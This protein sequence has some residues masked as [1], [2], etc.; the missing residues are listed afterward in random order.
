MGKV[1]AEMSM[2]LDGI[3]ADAADGIAE[4]FAWYGSGEVAVPTAN[5]QY[6][7]PV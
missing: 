2:W 4:V 3:V 5:P 1:V 6:V 7:F